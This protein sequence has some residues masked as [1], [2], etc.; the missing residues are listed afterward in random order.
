[1]DKVTAAFVGPELI[2]GEDGIKVHQDSCIR[3]LLEDFERATGEIL[4]GSGP[5]CRI[6]TKLA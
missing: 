1:M 5:R 4:R 3:Q 6:A 2:K